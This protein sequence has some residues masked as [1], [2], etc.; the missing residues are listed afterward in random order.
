MRK[1]ATST[2]SHGTR[3]RGEALA[4]VAIVLLSPCTPAPLL[5]IA[6]DRV[7][8]LYPDLVTALLEPY[9][10]GL[11]RGRGRTGSSSGNPA[12]DRWRRTAARP[13]RVLPV[14]E[15]PRGSL[16]QG[17]LPSD[18]YDATAN[19][20]AALDLYRSSRGPRPWR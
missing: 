5:V 2:T 6:A 18:R 17:R 16:H 20:L 12:G 14:D 9:R 11:A 7:A 13:P 10:L 3:T 1:P 8:P 19:T 4:V 15:G